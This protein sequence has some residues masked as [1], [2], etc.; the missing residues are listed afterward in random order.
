MLEALASGVPVVAT[1]TGC[2]PDVVV[3]G[4]NGFVV[5]ADGADIADKVVAVAAR[6]VEARQAEARGSAEAHSWSVVAAQYL[7]LMRD[8]L[9]ATFGGAR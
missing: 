5:R 4:D 1:A 2:V 8:R 9:G 6:P 3:D 7:D